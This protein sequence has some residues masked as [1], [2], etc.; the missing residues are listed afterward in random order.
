MGFRCVI[1]SRMFY[2][3]THNAIISNGLR[4][5]QIYTEQRQQLNAI[6]NTM[7]RIQIYI[8]YSRL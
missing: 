4:R 7:Y 1:I 5:I 3:F 6:Y 2:F 8:L